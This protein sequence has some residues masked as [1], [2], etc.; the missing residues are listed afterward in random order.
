[1]KQTN[2]YNDYAFEQIEAFLCDLINSDEVGSADIAMELNKI[3]AELEEYHA[4]KLNKIRDLRAAMFN[5]TTKTI[6]RDTREVLYEDII[7]SGSVD[8]IP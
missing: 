6:T 8:L 7:S 3:I 2:A 4:K 5:A 1:M